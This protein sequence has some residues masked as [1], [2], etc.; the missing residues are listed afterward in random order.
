MLNKTF[1]KKP[2]SVADPQPHNLKASSKLLLQTAKEL[3]ISM[4]ETLTVCLTTR[5]CQGILASQ[6]GKSDEQQIRKLS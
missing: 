3:V 2:S 6:G 4:V 1:F 5:K